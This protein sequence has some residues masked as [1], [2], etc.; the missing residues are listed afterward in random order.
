M[1]AAA[2]V[3]V[4]TLL[5]SPVRRLLVDTLTTR[6]SMTAAQLGE[7]VGLH[8]TTVRFHLD[9]L[10]AGGLLTSSFLRSGGAGRPKKVYAAATGSLAT[11]RRDSEGVAM[12]AELLAEVLR[13]GEDGEPPTPHEAG[14]RWAVEHVPESHEPPAQTPGRWMGKVGEMVDVLG[15]WGYTPEVSLTDGGRT[16]RINLAHCPFI[17]LAKK[18]PSVVCGIH[19]GLIAGAMEQLGEGEAEVSLEPFV[20][21][22]LCRAHV[23]ASLPLRP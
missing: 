4:A 6:G 3:D 10:E 13:P 8:V 2:H 17:D 15:Q 16:A 12:L 11:D 5:G 21:P 14:R 22:N 18:N 20:A 23:T 19:R 1:T 9:Q 7:I